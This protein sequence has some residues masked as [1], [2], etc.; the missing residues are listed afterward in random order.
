MN[1]LG[2]AGSLLSVVAGADYQINRWFVVG[3]F[4]DFDR[5]DMQTKVDVNIP[6]IPLTVSGRIEVDHQWSIGGRLVRPGR[7]PLI[8]G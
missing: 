3:A 2:A 5:V 4:F 1:G 6:P 7:K 8:R